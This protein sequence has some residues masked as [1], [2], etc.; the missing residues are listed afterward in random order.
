MIPSNQLLEAAE[1]LYR[2]RSDPLLFVQEIFPWGKGS[3]EKYSGP[4][5]WQSELLAT[6]RDNLSRD[7]PLRVAVASGHDI[8]K[9]TVLA[10][11]I[12][13]AVATEVDTRGI[14]TAITDTQLRTRTWAEV[15]KW[16]RLAELLQPL[17][18]CP[19]TSIHS[20]DD[21]H[22]KTWRIDAT[23]W[24]AT[25][26]DAFAGLHNRGRRLLIVM[27]EAS[28]ID[29]AIW[30]A[31]DGAMLDDDTEKIWL[32]FSQP[33][34]NSGRFKECF[35]RFR[36]N[37]IT[38]HIDSR[39]SGISNKQ[40]IA[41]WIRDWGE[42]SDYIR[43]KVRGV[44]PRAGSLQFISTELAE[45]AARREAAHGIHDPRIMG[46]DVARQGADQTVICVRIGRD[47]RT[48]EMIKMRIPDLMQIA[49]RVVEVA[50]K[51][52]VD[53]IFVDEGG[54]GAGVVDRLNYLRM[55]VTGIQFGSN[56]DYALQSANSA[57]AYAD[58]RAE[59]WGLMKD[60][61]SGG[62]IPD[63]PELIAD[64]TGVE[65]SHVLKDSRDAIRLEK[66]DDMRKR[67]L[68][69]PDA[70]DALALTFAFPVAPSDH[71]TELSRAG[72]AHEFNYEPFAGVYEV[73]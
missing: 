58:K 2:W 9:T 50:H 53:A 16:Y 55:P 11:I 10:W 17:F 15:G 14:V 73:R 60:W 39:A 51:Y 26:Q 56:P 48:V 38:K 33:R 46:V 23:P 70:A 45:G 29:D 52:K 69:S 4:D 40:E 41:D 37:W 1:H 27:D 36:H 63:D 49:A 44:F 18:A 43:V 64:L 3:L 35:G 72:Q 13:W 24:S 25:Q 65:Y 71:R 7:K 68:A 19:A 67:G 30:A 34:Q 66:K 31:C 22:K 20:T 61:L 54:L 21:A 8:G 57:A 42:D 6:L 47:A 32:A 62:A 5:E 12:L 59:M 28:D